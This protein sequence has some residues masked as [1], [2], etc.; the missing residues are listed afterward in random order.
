MIIIADKAIYE[1]TNLK[2]FSIK[3]YKV[4]NENFEQPVI[5][6]KSWT[7][8]IKTYNKIFPEDIQFTVWFDTGGAF[9][10]GLEEDRR[11]TSFGSKWSKAKKFSENDRL[12]VREFRK[13]QTMALK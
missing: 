12:K 1:N 5:G 4:Y 10:V 8:I 3:L 7:G 6:A 2:G 9:G 11:Q 13:S